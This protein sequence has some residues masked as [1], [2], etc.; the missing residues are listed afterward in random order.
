VKGAK[1]L[2]V[3]TAKSTPNREEPSILTKQG[4]CRSRNEA[5]G[6]VSVLSQPRGSATIGSRREN[7]IEKAEITALSAVKESAL[8]VSKSTGETGASAVSIG[9]TEEGHFQ[10]KRTALKN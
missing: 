3:P 1:V 9:S 7:G 6:G 2:R 8:V 10:K 4:G 5:L